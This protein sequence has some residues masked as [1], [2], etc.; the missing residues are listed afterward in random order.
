MNL[1]R[2]AWYIGLTEL[3]VLSLAP[4]VGTLKK[5]YLET[6]EHVVKFV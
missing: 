2:D 1:I 6:I 5:V 3:A 4:A